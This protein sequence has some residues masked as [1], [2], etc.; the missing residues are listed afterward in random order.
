MGLVQRED[1][2]DKEISRG[3]KYQGNILPLRKEI[4][5]SWVFSLAIPISHGCREWGE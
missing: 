2:E 4:S 1:L 5:K 3:R